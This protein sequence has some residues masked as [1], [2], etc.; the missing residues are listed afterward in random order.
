[1]KFTLP[2]IDV[3]KLARPVGLFQVLRDPTLYMHKKWF[4]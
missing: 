2:K 4:V 1:L 3:N